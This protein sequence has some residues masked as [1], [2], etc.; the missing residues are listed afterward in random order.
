[1][2]GRTVA[3][4]KRH[5]KEVNRMSYLAAWLEVLALGIDALVVV[6]VVLPTMFGP[7]RC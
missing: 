3:I 2:Q 7:V 1:M 6:D 4:C 5:I